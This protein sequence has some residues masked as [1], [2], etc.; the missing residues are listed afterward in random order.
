MVTGGVALTSLS[1]GAGCG[2]KLPAAALLPIVRGLPVSDDP[3]LLVSSDS[4]DDAAVFKISD[5]LALVMTIDFFTP[6]VD[7]PYDFGRIAAANAL[8]DVYAMGATPLAALNVVAFPLERLGGDVLREILRGGAD[9]AL[10]AG[11][12]IVGGHSIDD[13]EPKYGLAVTGTVHPAELVTNAGARAGD[14]L[15]LTKPL[16]VGAVVT[17][18]KRGVR[19]EALLADAVA[20]MAALNDA[21]SAA[22]RAAGAH[23]MTDVTGF[24][25]LGHLHGMARASGLAARVDAAAVP[26]IEGVIEL[27]EGEDAVSGGSARNREYAESFSSFA[28]GVPESRRRLV[29]DATTSGGLLVAVAPERAAEIPGFVVGEIIA[30]APGAIAVQ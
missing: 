9:V 29:C 18:R 8:S 3:R 19:D 1:H 21:P 30:G 24:G 26:A 10:L 25:L 16:G 20:T 4:A 7:D 27:L 2:C 12:P 28:A 13:P 11:A 15:V 23:A 6:I 5:E 17:A 22:A 14:L